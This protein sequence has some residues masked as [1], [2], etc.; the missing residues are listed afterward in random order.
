MSKTAIIIIGFAIFAIVMH[1]FA[2]YEM[3]HDYEVDPND[4]T[5]LD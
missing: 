1:A 3:K 4:K 5:L 2:I